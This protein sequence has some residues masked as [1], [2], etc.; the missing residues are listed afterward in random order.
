[1][2]GSW[3]RTFFKISQVIEEKLALSSNVLL[4]TEVFCKK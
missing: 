1:M 3:M 2:T 4:H